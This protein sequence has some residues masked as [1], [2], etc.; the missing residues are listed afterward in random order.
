MRK[1]A[2]STVCTFY[3]YALKTYA[4][5]YLTI[6]WLPTFTQEVFKIVQLGGNHKSLS[7]YRITA[8]EGVDSITMEYIDLHS[9]LG[10]NDL[11]G[12]IDL[13][14]NWS[15]VEGGVFSEELVTSY[16][17]IITKGNSLWGTIAGEGLPVGPTPPQGAFLKM[18]LNRKFSSLHRKLL[19]EEQEGRVPGPPSYY[20]RRGGGIPV[21]PSTNLCKDTKTASHSMFD[22]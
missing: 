10:V 7:I 14:T 8:A 9:C 6:F 18:C 21:L 15:E 5:I 17:L 13:N 19:R 3:T 12:H 11:N 2:V 16:P 20:T 1:R 4:V 22:N